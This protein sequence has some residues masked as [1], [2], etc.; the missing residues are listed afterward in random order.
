MGYESTDFA[1]AASLAI[2][3]ETTFA[4]GTH[5]GV[6]IGACVTTCVSSDIYAISCPYTISFNKATFAVTNV[7]PFST[8]DTIAN[9]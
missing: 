2:R 6:N 1:T 3:H 4:A 9:K 7:W 8:P 5:H